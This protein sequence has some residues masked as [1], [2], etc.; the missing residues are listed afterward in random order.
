MKKSGGVTPGASADA[1]ASTPLVAGGDDGSGDC[2]R[3]VWGK[4]DRGCLGAYNDVV[5]RLPSFQ[6]FMF[7]IISVAVLTVLS[8][9][10]DC[11]PPQSIQLIPRSR[12]IS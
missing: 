3:S 6:I 11:K 8:F 9:A 5:S 4:R 2:S 1:S 7:A 10:S 12:R